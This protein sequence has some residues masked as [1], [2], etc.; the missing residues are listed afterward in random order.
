MLRKAFER[1]FFGLLAVLAAAL[2]AACGSNA[3]GTGSSGGSGSS[4][5]PAGPYGNS[6]GDTIPNLVWQGYVNDRADALS[7]TKPY[8][9]YSTDDL[10]KSGPKLAL[11]HLSE[12]F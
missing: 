10:R 1:A 3:G 5:Y 9:H 6:L 12:F 2:L 11:V 7:T 8:V 4:S